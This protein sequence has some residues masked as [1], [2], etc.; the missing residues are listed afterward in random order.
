VDATPATNVKASD[1]GIAAFPGPRK[2]PTRANKSARKT[3]PRSTSRTSPLDEVE[4]A[5]ER[6]KPQSRAFEIA[7]ID[8]DSDDCLRDSHVD[9]LEV[10]PV[11]TSQNGES[12]RSLLGVDAREQFAESC[13][14]SHRAH[15]PLVILDRNLEPR[16]RVHGVITEPSV[17]PLTAP[18]T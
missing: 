7:G 4:S 12:A 16:I 3:A 5:T 10:G 17:D 6:A 13:R 11:G 9:G 1:T 8:V 14:L 18:G 15:V 2:N